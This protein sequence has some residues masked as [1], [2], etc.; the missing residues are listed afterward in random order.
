M[1]WIPIINKATKYIEEH[2]K[3]EIVLKDIAE[4]C[5]VSYHYFTKIFTLITGYTLKEY[6]RNR[7]ITLASYEI[8]YTSNR[9]IDV[10]VKYGYH[11]N[12]AFTRAFKKIHG[13][14]PSEA[15]K[16]N[17]S[18][19][20][21]FPVIHYDTHKNDL[22]SLKYNIIHDIDL[23]ITG[24]SINVI[25]DNPVTTHKMLDQFAGMVSRTMNAEGQ[26]YRVHYNLSST[27]KEYDYIVGYED[28]KE[29]SYDKVHIVAKKGVKFICQSLNKNLVVEAKKIIYHE[30]EKNDFV[31]DGTCEIE[32]LENNQDGTVNFFYIVSI[33]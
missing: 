25:E 28:I 10:A 27:N 1:S 5:N 23:E 29:D 21:H 24:K 6:I 13:I 18:V 3:E 22:I 31:E 17:V 12:E 33:K 20:T 7:R 2:I 11:S 14:N 15:R 9:I 4:E 8:S 30:W 26:M 16:N 32:Y 19:Y